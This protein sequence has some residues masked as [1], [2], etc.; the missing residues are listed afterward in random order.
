[1]RRWNL[2]LGH[3]AKRQPCEVCGRRWP[4]LRYTDGKLD[5]W[6]CLRHRSVVPEDSGAEAGQ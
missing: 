4:V 1:V 2:W 5:V 3:E 6:V